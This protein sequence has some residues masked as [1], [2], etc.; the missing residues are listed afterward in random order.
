MRIYTLPFL[1]MVVSFMLTF[2]LT[3]Q[4]ESTD[5]I[6]LPA[7]TV[8]PGKP[9]PP[10]FDMIQSQFENEMVSNAVLLRLKKENIA[11]L[12]NRVKAEQ[13]R[14]ILEIPYDNGRAIAFQLEINNLLAEG[15]SVN[16]PAGKYPYKPGLY[17]K[18]TVQGASNSLAAISIF[19][20]FVMG[21]FATEEGNYVIGPLKTVNG[22]ASDEY[23]LYKESNLKI[24]NDF[25]CYAD[26]L[27]EVEGKKHTGATHEKSLATAVVKVYFEC[28]YLMY[29]EKGSNATTVANFVSGAY[30]AVSTLYSNESINT[31]ISE[32]FVWTSQDPYRTSS[33]SNALTDFRSRLNSN[34]FNG[35]I[36]HLLS[37]TSNNLG[38]VA[39]VDVLCNRSYAYAYSNIN[40]TYQNFPT[41]SWTVN[42]ITHEMGHNLG[43]P[44]TQ[45]CNWPGGAIDNCYC[46]EG[47]C[48]AGPEPPATGG[49]IMSYCHL[50]GNTTSCT[51]PSGS[52]PG[53]NFTAGFGTLP[54]DLIRN[55]VDVAACL[56]GATPRPNL[57]AGSGSLT[58]N[59]TSINATI[60]V[61][62]NG[63]ASAGAS[64]VG[65]YLSTD[66]IFHATDYLFTTRSASAL[67][68]GATSTDIIV[69]MDLSTVIGIPTGTYYILFSIDKDNV[70]S[71]SNEN[72][73]IFYWNS[74]QVTIQGSC[75]APS[76][77]QI[78]ATNITT[79]SARFNCTVTG[80]SQYDWQYRIVGSATW[81][82]VAEGS[83]NFYDAIGLTAGAAYEF[84]SRVRCGT[85]TW[86]IWSSSFVFTT[87]AATCNAPTSTQISASNITSSGAQLNCS[88][89]GVNQYDWQYRRSGTT[90]WT[91]LP[92]GAANVYNVTGLT[93]NTSYE[94]QARVRCGT[95]TWSNWSP[96]R[97]FTTTALSCSRPTTSQ[98]SATNITNTTVRLNHS[99]NGYSSYGWRY[100]RSGTSAWTTLAATTTNYRDVTGLTRNTRYEFQVQVFCNNAWTTWSSSRTFTTTNTAGLPSEDELIVEG[101]LLPSNEDIA[102]DLN[103]KAYPQPANDELSLEFRIIQES[104]LQVNIFDLTGKLLKTI[105]LGDFTPGTYTSQI[106]LN[107]LRPGIYLLQMT[108]NQQLQRIKILIQ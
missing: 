40:S 61:T 96:S 30:N 87:T 84:Q 60:T 101:I 54:G 83:S 72:D 26:D 25:D 4:Q 52:N 102:L 97:T 85:T 53:V 33:S 70:V 78:S 65:Y 39:Y 79:N 91:S 80:V 67:A 94:F 57:T 7:P 29:Q 99:L 71:E 108:G 103:L 43:S 55:R 50:S 27:P 24:T 42:V 68:N 90:T 41:Y 9:L 6:A 19:D 82:N 17:L 44:H 59:G 28:D 95:T 20:D 22:I 73:N 48:A 75:I 14:V 56:S 34:G 11:A 62:N 88:V 86:S 36:A 32:I 15:F 93:S 81:I 45:S 3:A 104:Q 77:S 100:R 66:N 76:A 92:E 38:G 23:I 5:R 51:L 46:P 89:T 18:G 1:F 98:I 74:P 37:R 106:P 47:S 35:D 63:T 2:P 107:Q 8:S 16:T 64:T 49:T 31:Q 13:G 105:P 69:N 21:V 12:T 58:V 10:I